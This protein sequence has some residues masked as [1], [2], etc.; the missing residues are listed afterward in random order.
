VTARAVR[1]VVL[2]VFAGGIAGMIATSIADA[3]GWALAFGLL[4]AAAAV[5]LMA[6][7]AATAGGRAPGGE[8]LGAAVEERVARLVAQGADED[9]V[10]A[11]VADAVRLGRG[12]PSGR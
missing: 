5:C 1:A 11:L 8:A 9:E 7:T 2:V 12:R 10:R 6:V 3:T 4:T